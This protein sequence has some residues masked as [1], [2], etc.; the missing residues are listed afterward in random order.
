VVVVVG[1]R[2]IGPRWEFE[3]E[4]GEWET[5]DKLTTRLLEG[6]DCRSLTSNITASRTFCSLAAALMPMDGGNTE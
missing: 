6:T 1:I 2:D 5:Y 3:K 4:D